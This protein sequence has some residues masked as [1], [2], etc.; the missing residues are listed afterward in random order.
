MTS[1][2]LGVVSVAGVIAALI[3]HFGPGVAVAG[4]PTA[5]CNGA[6][7]SAFA[8]TYDSLASKGY[9][10][11]LD[12]QTLMLCSNPVPGGPSGSWG[13]SSLIRTNASCSDGDGCPNSIVQ[14]G[15]G[16]CRYSQYSGCQNGTAQRLF[17]AYGRDGGAQGCQGLNDIEPVPLDRG[18]APTDTGLHYYRVWLDG[19]TW[20]FD[21]WPKGQSVTQAFTLSASI[22]CWTQ[23][24]GVSFAE[25]WDRADA[26]GGSTTNHY[27]F[28]SMTRMTAGGVWQPTLGQPCVVSVSNPPIPYFYHC[29]ET[30]AQSWDAWTDR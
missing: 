1:R 14:I 26:L 18:A 22:I 17:A 4:P 2:R 19:S 27:N 28:L 24:Q 29:D 5:N 9:Y 21:H 20:R 23:R 7:S 11:H 12:P 16:A 6:Y 13:W 30:G 8:S 3:M 25:S 15:R 10:S